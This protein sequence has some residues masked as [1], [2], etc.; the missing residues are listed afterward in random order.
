MSKTYW[1]IKPNPRNNWTRADWDMQRFFK[2]LGARVKAT[3]HNG[4]AYV[5][6]YNEVK[7]SHSLI[8]KSKM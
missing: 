6:V 3:I 4:Y 8:F 1:D 2:K 7:P 5:V